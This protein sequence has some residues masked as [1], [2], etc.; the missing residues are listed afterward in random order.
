MSQTQSVSDAHSYPPWRCRGEAFILNYWF[1]PVA[2]KQLQHFGIQAQRVGH[3]LHVLLIRYQQSPVGPYDAL[4]IID[5]PQIAKQRCSSIPL[6]FVSTPASIT[7]G[8]HFWG[9]PKQQA[10]FIWHEQA[11]QLSCSIEYQQQ[12]LHL[13]LEKHKN[14][15]CYDFNHQQLTQTILS[16]HQNWQNQHY[17][18]QPNFRAKLCK[19]KKVSWQQSTNSFIPNFQ[20]ARYIQSF[21]LPE[22]QLTLPQAVITQVSRET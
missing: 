2:L 12:Q 5:H 13:K 16:I 9:L 19:L 10:Q 18:F 3:L 8:Q 17:K 20:D 7:D 15:T 11:E 4:V 14:S 21:Y 22:F 6:I 1:S